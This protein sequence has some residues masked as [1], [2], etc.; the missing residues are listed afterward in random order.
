[1]GCK[2]FSYV[3]DTGK[4]DQS[5]ST[6]LLASICV[7]TAT[8]KFEKKVINRFVVR[9]EISSIMMTMPCSIKPLDIG[10]CY[11]KLNSL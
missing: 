11:G 5:V 2:F 3:F 1:M 10:V 8:W 6:P 9:I 4:S 7:D